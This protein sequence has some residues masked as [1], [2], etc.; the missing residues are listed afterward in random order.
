MAIPNATV[1]ILLENGTRFSRLISDTDGNF[2][3][4]KIP[5][6]CYWVLTDKKGYL[7]S[8]VSV[9]VDKVEMAV[10]QVRLV[11]IT[12]GNI[13][14]SVLD[15]LTKDGIGG[16]V[17]RIPDMA[18]S[19]E[20][21]LGG[22]YAFFDLPSGD[23]DIEVSVAGYL[24]SNATVTVKNNSTSNKDFHMILSTGNLKGR[25]TDNET[26]LPVSNATLLIPDVMGQITDE[27][28]QYLMVGIPVGTRVLEVGAGGYSTKT[29]TVEI[30]SGNTTYLDIQ[31]SAIVIP[32][33]PNGTI[34]G[35]VFNKKG[36]KPIF[37]AL[38]NIKEL[39]R[40]ILTDENGY[41]SLTKVRP[42]T[43]TIEV[44]AKGYKTGSR[45]ITLEEQENEVLSFHLKKKDQKNVEDVIGATL[46][47]AIFLIILIVF[48]VLLYLRVKRGLA[49]AAEMEKE[50]VPEDEEE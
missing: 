42:G 6:G 40:T 38:V 17:V 10:V 25:V 23:Y 30:T 22:G 15:N 3:Y 8:N 49:K 12:W 34:S 24:P 33:D 29:V 43:Y 21:N 47:M 4:V 5:T 27:N 45:V 19:T 14:G 11:Q 36:L 46:A 26:D 18:L 28:G 35:H 2:S 37:R 31:L 41:F 13:I 32:S 48:S 44:T 7:P 16:A 50:K 9:C 20:T 1:D 39:N